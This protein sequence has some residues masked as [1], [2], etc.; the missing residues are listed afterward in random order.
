[1]FSVR[2]PLAMLLACHHR[3]FESDRDVFTRITKAIAIIS[4]RYNV[5]CNLQS[6]DQERLYNDI[7]VKI[8]N[9]TYVTYQQVLTA[10][11]AVY[12]DD[13]Q[14]KNAFATK[15]LRTTYSRNKKVVRYILFAIEKQK[16]GQALDFESATYNL[17]HI[18]P[19]NPA[20]AWSAIEEVKQDRL[21]Y[22]LGNMTLLKTS[23]NRDL[24]NGGYEV[25]R[26]VYAQSDC[27]ITQAIAEHYDTWNE[28]KI[29]S[30][31]KHLAKIAAGIWRIE[32][33]G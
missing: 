33:G 26:A 21:I 22:R 13:D 2:Q 28:A 14:F 7:A 12:P 18:L 31:Q 5:I 24:G 6:H 20:A 1:M 25:K 8:S 27:Q 29:E 3:F 15:E 17:E 23:R 11:Q 9:Q 16:S 4:F 30:R 10:L 19:E 32:F